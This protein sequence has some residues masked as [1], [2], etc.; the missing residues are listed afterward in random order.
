MV[1]VL[2]GGCVR[3]VVSMVNV[4]VGSGRLQLPQLCVGVWVW[5]G[6]RGVI[7]MVWSWCEGSLCYAFMHFSPVSPGEHL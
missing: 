4:L 1:C 3:V 2:G 5:A 7:I 6:E